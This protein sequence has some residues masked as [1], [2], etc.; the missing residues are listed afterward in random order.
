[1][2]AINKYKLKRV[3]SGGTNNSTKYWGKFQ[4][5]KKDGGCTIITPGCPCGPAPNVTTTSSIITLTPLTFTIHTAFYNFGIV[6][7]TSFNIACD[8][9]QN[10]KTLTP[11]SS[12][13]ITIFD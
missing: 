1:M 4:Y 8:G 5:Q 12:F 10:P 6:S 13:S 9:M 2:G 3:I 11:T 7:G